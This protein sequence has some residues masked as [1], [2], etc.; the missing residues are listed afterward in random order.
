MCSEGE[1]AH[2]QKTGP[3]GTLHTYTRRARE[4]TQGPRLARGWC[5]AP[6]TVGKHFQCP[7][8]TPT[9]TDYVFDKHMGHCTGGSP[10]PASTG[11]VSKDRYI[12]MTQPWI[13][14]FFMD[15]RGLGCCASLD[16][17]LAPPRACGRA[18]AG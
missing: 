11:N 1:I 16:D 17:P 14:A 8:A 18:R 13:V 6:S 4:L 12:Y 9:C 15:C 7:E 3:R 5:P 2:A 10:A